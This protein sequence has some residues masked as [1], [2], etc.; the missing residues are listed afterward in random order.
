MQIIG[1]DFVVLCDSA[2]SVIK[3]GGICFDTQRILEID[4]YENLCAKYK[5]IQCTYYDSC[6]ITPALANPHLHL[7]FSQNAG[8]LKFGDFGE[9]LDSV[10]TQREVLMQGD[11]QNA[12]Q[13]S[14]QECLKSG[15]GFIGAISSHGADLEVLA[16][17]P[18]RVMYFNEAIGSSIEA[19]DFLYQNFLARLKDSK[20]KA[21]AR[22]IPAVAVHSPYSVHPKLLEKVLDVAKKENLP[23]SV[24]FLESYAEKEWLE[25]SSGYFKG[26]YE[27]FFHKEVQTFYS[28]KEF[29]QAFNGIENVYFTHC[30]E[31]DGEI[32]ERIKAQKGKII[33]CPKS[34][35]L[36]NHK[37]LDLQAVKKAQIPFCLGTDGKSSNDSLSLLDELRIAL[38]AYADMPLE[39]LA[40]ELLLSVTRN[41][42]V[43]STLPLGEL[44]V[45]NFSDFSVFKLL[46]VDTFLAQHL[47]LYAKEAHRL[48]IQGVE[49]LESK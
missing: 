15:V 9:W 34:N 24:H 11:L 17:S 16:N 19:L 44:K 35:R 4:S 12:M 13:Q 18:L 46:K 14:L 36:L 37:Y 49:V 43:D 7:E 29:L 27:R 5:G 33:S 6:A 21:S 30:L 38:F 20:S 42:F 39:F 23:L 26:F 25:S 10:L 28:A 47:I 48:Y 3:K 1:A 32:L 2:F 40:R 41:V 31:A 8:I 45:G 22:F